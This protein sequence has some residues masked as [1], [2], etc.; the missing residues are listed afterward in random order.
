MKERKGRRVC[1]LPQRRRPPTQKST[2]AGNTTITRDDACRETVTEAEGRAR[3]LR[4]K[5]SACA[6]SRG[7]NGSGWCRKSGSPRAKRQR[8]RRR[9]GRGRDAAP[10][11]GGRVQG[12]PV[13]QREGALPRG[14][15][16]RG[17]LTPRGIASPRHDSWDGDWPARRGQ[18]R[19]ARRRAAAP[20]RGGRDGGWP[21]LMWHI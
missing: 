6:S 12:R 14:S 4:A 1:A 13:R 9:G 3:E 7:G 17:R 15:G 11:R 20:P 2:R 21:A 8:W 19:P 5:V 18:S 16:D 10:P